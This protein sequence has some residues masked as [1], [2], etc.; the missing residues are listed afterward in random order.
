VSTR[1][2]DL[3]QAARGREEVQMMAIEQVSPEFAM[4]SEPIE[5]A[6]VVLA[7]RGELDIATAPRLR[8]ELVGAIAAGAR[9]LVIDLSRVSFLD[10]VSLATLI[11]V[12]RQVPERMAVVVAR[13]SYARL[14]FE[15]AGLPRGLDIFETRDAAVAHITG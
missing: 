15:I 3:S 7:V 5:P 13:D 14:I 11:S 8:A 6:G 4:S 1:A 9:R 10:S 12:R 2:L